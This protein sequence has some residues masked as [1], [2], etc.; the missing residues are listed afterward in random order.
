MNIK[1]SNSYRAIFTTCV[2]AGQF[3]NCD[4]ELFTH[5]I[6]DEAAQITEPECLIPIAAA[7]NSKVILAGDPKQLGAVVKSGLAKKSGLDVS[8]VERLMENKLYEQKTHS[9]AGQG[10][11]NPKLITKLTKNY[12]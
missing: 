4:N 8:L 6:I 5:V 12:R 10:G 1:I 2:N 11:Y 7:P 3:F 9:E